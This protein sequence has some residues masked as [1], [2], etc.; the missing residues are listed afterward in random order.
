M[1]HG[2]MQLGQAEIPPSEASR[3]WVVAAEAL[4]WMGPEPM[5]KTAEAVAEAASAFS[6]PALACQDKVSMVP[7]TLALLATVVA[8]VAVA[9]AARPRLAETPAAPA[10]PDTPSLL[11]GGRRPSRLARL[12]VSAAAVA[13][14]RI[15]GPLGLLRTGAG[16]VVAPATEVA[17]MP[18]PTLAAAAAALAEA[19]VQ[20]RQ[21]AERET[22]AP[23]L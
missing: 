20:P 16:K 5:D 6:L 11:S 10:A 1:C 21:V 17:S 3:R 18:W 8:A 22:V 12:A 4:T 14:D 2:F 19:Q 23:A 9:L 13:A 15:R 7:P